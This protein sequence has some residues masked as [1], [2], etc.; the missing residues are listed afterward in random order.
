PKEV[1]R[2]LEEANAV[3]KGNY[4]LEE[5]YSEWAA[6]RR[7]ALQRAWVGLLLKLTNLRVEQGAYSGALETLDRLRIADPTNETALQRLMILLTQLDRRGEALQVYRQHVS[8]LQRDYESEPLPETIELYKTLR[9]GHVPTMYAVRPATLELSESSEE[10]EEVDPPR[11]A[12]VNTQP[13][14]ALQGA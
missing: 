4:L 13:S 12:T 2:L 1:E 11:I 5:L 8:M 9:Q 10:L 14:L 3:Y 6:P 7:D